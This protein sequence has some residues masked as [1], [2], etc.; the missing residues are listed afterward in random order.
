MPTFVHGKGTRV[1]LDEFEMT[2]YFNSAD[3]TLT[4]ET[5]EITAFGATSKAY[6]LGLADGTLSMGGMWNQET[7]GSDEELHAILPSGE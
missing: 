7:D 1:Y 6:L 5:A 3:V 2:T 4:N